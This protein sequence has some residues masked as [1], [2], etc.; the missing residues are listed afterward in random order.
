MP[1]PSTAP[2]GGC[3][4]L[5]FHWDR[6][7][8]QH[9]TSKASPVDFPHWLSESPSQLT[10]DGFI[11]DTMAHLAELTDGAR[12]PALVL[13]HPDQAASVCVR[14]GHIEAHPFVQARLAELPEH[15]SLVL[16]HRVE[17]G[18]GCDGLTSVSSFGASL[19]A[20]PAA[21]LRQAFS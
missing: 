11:T 4:G 20:R 16:I 1:A 7:S 5:C 2:L 21:P 15:Q 9:V 10:V 17:L 6:D 19:F 3:H 14:L 13:R 12:G 8:L 18:G